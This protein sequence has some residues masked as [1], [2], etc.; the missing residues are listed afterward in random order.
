MTERDIQRLEN[1]LRRTRQAPLSAQQKA[2]EHK[3]VVSGLRRAGP[4]AAKLAGAAL[5]YLTL[6]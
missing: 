1:I 3:R 5:I 4:L 2:R 6:L